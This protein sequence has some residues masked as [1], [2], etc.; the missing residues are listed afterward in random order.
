M[1]ELHSHSGDLF[2]QPAFEAFCAR[3]DHRLPRFLVR[4]GEQLE[5]ARRRIGSK[6]Q[7]TALDGTKYRDW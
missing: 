4:S 5:Q 2:D 1:R 7:G 6:A 3:G